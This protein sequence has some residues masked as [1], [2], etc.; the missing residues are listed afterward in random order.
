MTKKEILRDTSSEEEIKKAYGKM[1]WCYPIVERIFEKGIRGKCLELLKLQ[2]G[3]SVL[4]IGFGTGYALIEFA[5]SVGER[6]EVYGIDLTPEMLKLAE[7][8]IEKER[9][10]ERIKLYEGNAKSL[11]YENNMFDVVY[12]SFTLELLS[13]QDIS[14][15]L[16]EI[17]RVLKP[18][19]RLGVI[20][21]AKEGYEDSRILKLYEW[22]HQKIP[23]YS[24]CP[25]YIEDNLKDAGYKIINTYE[26][27]MAYLFPVSTVIAKP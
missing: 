27:K 22:I 14:R 24:S 17:K 23:D 10:E 11:P 6:G 16:K 1:S 19:G 18:N 13:T 2:E 8:R 4:E 26:T 7:K 21:V 5:K 3:E 25:I 20:S 12:T 9:L 15:V